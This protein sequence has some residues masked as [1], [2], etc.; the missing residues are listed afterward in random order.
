MVQ[1]D[2]DMK[3]LAVVMNFNDVYTPKKR[4]REGHRGE[5]KTPGQGAE[6]GKK[7]GG[8]RTVSAAV[9]DMGKSKERE[10]EKEKEKEKENGKPGGGAVGAASKLNEKAGRV[11]VK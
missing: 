6:T 9:G 7:E 10:K 2:V 4:R 5:K 8:S 1:P 11:P 3:F